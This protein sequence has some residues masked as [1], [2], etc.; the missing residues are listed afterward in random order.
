M[1]R[2]RTRCLVAATV[3]VL[4][5]GTGAGPASAA[6]AP[7]PATPSAA[8]SAVTASA[9]AIS[10]GAGHTCALVAGGAVKCWGRNDYGQL[11]INSTADSLI[12]ADVT[13]ISGAT[14]ISAGGWHTCALVAGGAVQ[15][16]G[17]NDYGQLGN[18][19]TTSSPVP[20]DVTGIS[21]ATAISAGYEHTCAL[22]AGGAV[23]CWGRNPYGQLGNGS[24]TDSPVPVA[25]A[26]LSGATAVSAGMGHTCALVAGGAVEC[27][28]YNSDGELGDGTTHQDCG[29]YDCSPAPVAVAGISGGTAIDAGL[30]HT[31]AL[32]AAGSVK[33]W[34]LNS[35][36]EL[37]NN[38]TT[39]SPVPVAATGIS[40]AT[41]IGAGWY[42]TCAVAVAGGVKCWGY[43]L[44]GRLG[45]NSTTSSPVPV[46]VTGISGATAVGAG[47]AHSCALVAGGAVKCWGD[48]ASGQLGNNSTI[49]S[50]IPV[51]VVGLG[52]GTG[53]SV[54]PADGPWYGG[55]SVTVI[56]AGLG[57]TTSV[58]FGDRAATS[59]QQVSTTELTAVVPSEPSPSAK[60]GP[61]VAV[62]VHALGGDVAVGTYT[63]RGVAVV[64]MRGWMSSMGS[65][66]E[67]E[68]TW[69]RNAN[70]DGY[71]KFLEGGQ[72]IGAPAWPPDVFVDF[73]YQPGPAQSAAFGLPYTPCDTIVHLH[74][75][76]DLLD[77]EISN[78][79]LTHP[80]V[81]IYL[82]GHSQ[83]GALALGY[84]AYLKEHGRSYTTPAT[85]A[86]LAG[87]VTLDSP[88]GGFDDKATAVGGVRSAITC[89]GYTA[90]DFQDFGG[91]P[92]TNALGRLPVD[93]PWGGL[94]SIEQL[95]GMSGPLDNQDLAPAAGA[96][97]VAV[98]SVGN[99]RDESY[100]TSGWYS[101][102]FL[103]NGGAGTNVYSREMHIAEPACSSN[104]D[105]GD[106]LVCQVSHGAVQ[107]SAVVDR[108][109]AAL[110]SGQA[111]TNDPSD[112]W[113][114]ISQV[115]A[116]GHA[117]VD[118]LGAVIW[119]N[120][121]LGTLKVDAG[122]QAVSGLVTLAGSVL[123]GSP[124]VGMSQAGVPYQ[125]T[126]LQ[127][128]AGTSATLTF[129]YSTAAGGLGSTV[130]VYKVTPALAPMTRTSAAAAT[131]AWTPV[132]TAV[133]P[134]TGDVTATIT[135]DGLYVPVAVDPPAIT[136]PTALTN[137]GTVEFSVTFGE[138]VTGVAAA[139]FTLSGTATGCAVGDPAG[140]GA[141]YS[142]AVSGCS[143]GTVALALRA[144]SVADAAGNSAPSADITSAT[145]TID[146]TAPMP[147]LAATPSVSPTNATSF[148]VT[149]AFGKPVSGFTAAEVTLGGTST[150]WSVGTVS[151]SG[152]GRAFTVGAAAPTDGTLTIRLPAGASSDLAANPTLASNTLAFTIDRTP[153]SAVL[154]APATPSDA[155]TLP[156][157][158]TF[159]EPV[160]GLA[161]GDFTL[162]GTA[163]GCAVDDP[164][165]SGA[166]YSVTVSGCSEGTVALTLEAGSVA[167][168]AGNAGPAAPAAA[169]VVMVAR[170]TPT[171][172]L[173][174]TPGSGWTAASSVSCTVTFSAAPGQGSAFTAADVLVGGTATGWTA[175]AP[176][177]TGAGPYAFT[178]AG[179]AGGTIT[180]ATAAGA[181]A[182]G[183][184]TPAAASNTIALSIDT[185][186]PTAS[187]PVA[188]LAAG[189]TI[190]STIP[191]T[192][193]WA[194][195]DA[196]SGIARYEL[197]QSTNGGAY[198]TVASPT[199]VSAVR[200][201]APSA[202]RTYRFRVRAIDTAGNASAWA[203]GPV[204]HVHLVQESSTAL[205][206]AGG[207]VTAS[208]ASASGGRYRYATR[209]GASVSYTFTGRN[210]AFVAYKGAKL[211]SVRVYLN[212]AYKGTVSE[213]ASATAWRR[214]L[215]ST[216]WSSSGSHTLRL[217]WAG[218]GARP[219]VNVDALVVLG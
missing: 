133:D 217:V 12:P 123:G 164:A 54:S 35:D 28:G 108:G 62:V 127:P 93:W 219:R 179:I 208:S 95:W 24:T 107:S 187:A 55:S 193:A 192:L 40:G 27:W 119:T 33:C 218:T 22:V 16:W 157:A 87:V 18:N 14:A 125:V 109:I 85:G 6:G 145:V 207:W 65:S 138:P 88:L 2:W 155:A 53:L 151:G 202:T 113:A 141:A 203:Y 210:V 58:T 136:P 135:G 75:S 137:A 216:R 66:P 32:A 97:G 146:R 215:W 175:G 196:G 134:V 51:D 99:L 199:G 209:S 11:G 20:V 104:T 111:P 31:C 198:A 94:A 4:L 195:A 96:A 73:S 176:A 161:A 174:C 81:D 126:G 45:N 72:G 98:L 74:D 183:L 178:V 37:G 9:T 144:G 59:F 44:Y 46:D 86:H 15:C 149:A 158:L 173:V 194:G 115:E 142:V 140:S 78:Y 79:V 148:A 17:W 67:T 23:K 188:T 172:A 103:S 114:P 197:A 116:I 3:A 143:E 106:Y 7:L 19:S 152:A 112:W 101:S 139:D 48:N 70:P 41:A 170:A 100:F 25:V 118:A 213:Y 83:G 105:P 212:G 186:P 182:D 36:G 191:V 166:A 8:L 132:A 56:G 21:G 184:G 34:G 211:G 204:F 131:G 185:T 110:I 71:V 89:P 163:T 5:T 61:P 10:A 169:A 156:Y 68:T 91:L 1:E 42:H 162:S 153:P 205:R 159:G 129:P 121:F 165:G 150:G 76:E 64:A 147:V 102:Q 180:I 38:S 63:Y 77:H 43:N 124:P 189:A 206:W 90:A 154:T 214:L 84:L 181:I 171:A 60:T 69:P 52:G 29:G 30:D 26:G 168:A 39:S 190:G 117:T 92:G 130:T 120:D 50:L 49:G 177:G 47:Y 122:V 128:N 200:P 82:V 167:D 13:G 57:G 80:D 201:L 160:S